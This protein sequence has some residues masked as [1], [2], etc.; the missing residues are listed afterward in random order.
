MVGRGQA[1][2]HDVVQ[3]P[4]HDLLDLG[5]RHVGPLPGHPLGQLRLLGPQQAVRVQL[6]LPDLALHAHLATLQV[7]V[8]AHYALGLLDEL[9]RVASLSR[10]VGYRGSAFARNQIAHLNAQFSQ[11]TAQQPQRITN[12]VVNL[13]RN[14]LFEKKLLGSLSLL[15]FLTWA[16]SCL[17]LFCRSVLF[18]FS[19]VMSDST[20][21]LKAGVCK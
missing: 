3:L 14:F 15:S 20:R 11:A 18:C 8:V 5:L 13:K 6:Q 19:A 21:S 1:R 12:E 17:S 10:N 4:P 9:G 16:L 7:V 2:V